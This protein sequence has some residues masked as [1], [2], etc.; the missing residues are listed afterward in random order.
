MAAPTW[1]TEG[2]S[3]VRKAQIERDWARRDRNKAQRFKIADWT[4]D[5]SILR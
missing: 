2:A 5:R 3:E 1:M 4:G